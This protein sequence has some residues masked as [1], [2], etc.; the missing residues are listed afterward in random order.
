MPHDTE[1]VVPMTPMRDA[2]RLTRCVEG[3]GVLPARRFRWMAALRHRVREGYYASDTMMDAVAR[4]LLAG[5]E[6]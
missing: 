6:M 5:G 4:R 3:A 1:W 2:D